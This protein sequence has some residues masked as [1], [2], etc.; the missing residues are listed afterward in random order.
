MKIPDQALQQELHEM[1]AP[2]NYQATLPMAEQ[3]AHDDRAQAQLIGAG[4][5]LDNGW[6]RWHYVVDEDNGT[7]GQITLQLQVAQQIS[8]WKKIEISAIIPGHSWPL[9]RTI[10]TSGNTRVATTDI[11]RSAAFGETLELKFW[12]AGFLNTA[13]YLDTMQLGVES[14]L[15]KVVVFICDRD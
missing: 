3:L 1:I 12:K 11:T 7:P 14:H 6:D 9:I 4:T 13:S 8:W 10:G 15:G 5:F 2:R